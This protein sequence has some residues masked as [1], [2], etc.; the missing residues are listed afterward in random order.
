MT[1][2]VRYMP[3]V[4][5]MERAKEFFRTLSKATELGEHELREHGRNATRPAMG[6]CSHKLA[7]DRG[8]SY[9]YTGNIMDALE[10]EGWITGPD[11]HGA[12][13]LGKRMS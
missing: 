7:R 12:R 11:C 5:H 6:G 9:N 3:P 4:E 10:R 8:W 2:Q 1:R 13:R